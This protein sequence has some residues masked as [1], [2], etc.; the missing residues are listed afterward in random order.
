MSEPVFKLQT[1]QAIVRERKELF[2]EIPCKEVLTPE[3][4]AS[5]QRALKA[6]GAYDGSISGEMDPR[7]RRALRRF[8]AADGL[9]S[10]ILSLQTARKLGL[11]AVPRDGY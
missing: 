7:T 5:V 9:N 6:R 2:F 10:S 8:Q 1:R 3:F 4:I 11:I